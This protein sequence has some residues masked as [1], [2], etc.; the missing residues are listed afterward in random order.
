M[1][2]FTKYFYA[3]EILKILFM[4]RQITEGIPLENID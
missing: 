1:I 3:S 2:G 4:Q